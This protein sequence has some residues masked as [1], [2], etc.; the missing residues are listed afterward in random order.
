MDSHD[1]SVEKVKYSNKWEICVR[2]T[3]RLNKWHYIL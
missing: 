1:R 3:T 2:I